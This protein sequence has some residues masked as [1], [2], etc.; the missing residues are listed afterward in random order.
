MARR[1]YLATEPLYCPGEWYSQPNHCTPLS[2]LSLSFARY[3]NSFPFL[4]LR[5]YDR[6]SRWLLPMPRSVFS[7]P[8]IRNRYPGIDRNVSM[9][10]SNSLGKHPSHRSR[11]KRKGKKRGEFRASWLISPLLSFLNLAPL[12]SLYPNNQ[13]RGRE[14]VVIIIIQCVIEITRVR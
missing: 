13:T 9:A 8:T 4:L 7:R 5:L 11:K 12:Y 14:G 3:S 10:S 2:S 1:Y 6:H